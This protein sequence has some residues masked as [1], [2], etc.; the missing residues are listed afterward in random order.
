MSN[1][2]VLIIYHGDCHDGFTGAWILHKVYPNA[3][4]FAGKYG[5][6]A[7]PEVKDRHVIM[8]DFSYDR[9]TL[10]DVADVAKSLVVM[11]HHKTAQEN[12]ADFDHYRAKIVFDM[13]KS[14]ASIAWDYYFPYKPV[15]S[16]VKYVEDRDLWK[17]R[18]QYSK[19]IHAS[20]SSRDQTFDNW[21]K[22]SHDLETD[23]NKIFHEGVSILRKQKK[24]IDDLLRKTTHKK[25][26]GGYEV[27]VANVP[28]MMASDAANIL[29]QGE[30]FAATFYI[31]NNGHYVFSLRS[32]V[33][34]MDVSSIAKQYGGGGHKHAAGFTISDLKTT[35]I[36]GI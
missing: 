21:D 36:K 27:P 32:D 3:E 24:D 29:A 28:F 17:F 13:E 9:E 4:F 8:V 15:P 31:D 10:L 19:E 7:M 35:V 14:G 6:K 20:L 16:I 33:N 5:S 2:N 12:L 11:D 34:G 1:K 25:F 18:E 30:K 22:F 26:I 23:F